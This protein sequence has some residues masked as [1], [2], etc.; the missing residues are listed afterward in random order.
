MTAELDYI[1]V[2]GFKSLQDVERLKLG[3]MC[4]EKSGHV[5][6]FN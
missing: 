6:L 3:L 5:I 4:P 1:T 2:K